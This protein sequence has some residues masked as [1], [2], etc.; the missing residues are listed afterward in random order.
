MRSYADTPK[1][2]IDDYKVVQI[3]ALIVTRTFIMKKIS[4]MKAQRR[5]PVA[6]VLHRF[7][8][9]LV[10]QHTHTMSLPVNLFAPQQLGRND[11]LVVVPMDSQP[12][13]PDAHAHLYYIYVRINWLDEMQANNDRI[14]RYSQR[15]SIIRSN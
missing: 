13:M 10:T 7:R 5:F 14:A 15:N 3:C 1:T 8:A 9:K 2:S 11:K 4:I 6:M 12:I